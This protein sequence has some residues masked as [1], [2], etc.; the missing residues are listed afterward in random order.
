MI[1]L[2]CLVIIVSCQTDNQT[3]TIEGL[4]KTNDS[5]TS[6]LKEIE[7]KYVF[8]SIS[9]R[10][11]PNPKNTTKLNSEYGLELIVVGYSPNKNYFV[12]YDTIINGKKINP[13]TLKQSNGG[14]KYRTKLEDNKTPIWIEMDISNEYG[15]SKKGTLYDVIK[16]K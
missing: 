2:F 15:K 4:K 1:L 12:K 14:F 9:F 8:D 5:L 10:E 16:T 6:I 11:I 3:K 13:D 7:G